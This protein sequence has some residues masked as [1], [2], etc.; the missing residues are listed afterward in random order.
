MNFRNLLLIPCLLSGLMGAARGE[1]VISQ[2]YEGTSFNKWIELANT[3]DTAVSLDGFVLTRWAN[4]ATESW[5]QDGASPSGSDSLDGLS[6]PA[7]GFL[8][9]GNTRAVVPAYAAADVS[10]NGTPNFNGDDSVVLYD[11]ALGALGDT[12]AI[13]DA[14]SFTDTGNEGANRSFYRIGD[15][16][17]FDLLAGS[18]VED[19]PQVWAVTSNQEVDEAL[20]GDLFYLQMT[21][22]TYTRFLKMPKYTP[23][24]S[25]TCF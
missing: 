24:Q 9:F 18:T 19:Y 23:R 20:P 5:K 15:S 4:A 16:V 13:V 25:L 10:T 2:Y 1:V 14:L 21:K 11:T 7:N 17:G 6:I 12:V 22:C 3:S 8:L